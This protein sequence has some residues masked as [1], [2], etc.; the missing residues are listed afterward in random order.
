MPKCQA[1]KSI[2]RKVI[3]GFKFPLGV[4][5]IEEMKPRPGYTLLFESADGSNEEGEWEEWP[6]R[7]VFDCV[8]S[9]ERVESLCRLVFSLLPG[10]VYPIVDMLGHDAHREIDPYITY[11][12]VGLDSFLEN[13]RRFR[14][15]F[16]ED[17]LVGF[18][19][20]SEEPFFYAFVDEHKIVT[21]RAEPDMKEKVER[22]LAAFGLEQIEEPA[23]A[24][25]AAHEH[26][27][28]LLTPKN[29]P[30][31]LGA[32][33]ILE[34]LRDEWALMLNVDAE[35][36]L[37]DSGAEL[38]LTPWRCVVRW[39]TDPRR[40]AEV[41]LGASNLREAEELAVEAFKA[42]PEAPEEDEAIDVIISD[43]LTAES[44]AEL[45]SPP[46]PTATTQK[47]KSGGPGPVEQGHIYLSRWIP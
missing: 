12:L 30:E 7:Y 33:E 14:D 46:P 4:Y 29:R 31:L 18:G 19:A 38:G 41:I 6:D 44:F 13:V 11:N 26:R 47:R 40:Y 27:S 10:R 37:D 42:L 5:P 21:I 9:A 39:D 43:R 8:V 28:A 45:T 3:E 15:F 36:N 16:F 24:D 1:D 34:F 2:D 23:G 17:G 20:M 35:S 32:E 22:I 25:A